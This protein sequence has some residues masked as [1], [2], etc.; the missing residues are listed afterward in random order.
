ML[1]SQIVGRNRAHMRKIKGDG[2]V[3]MLKFRILVSQRFFWW[4]KSRLQHEENICAFLSCF[5]D[6]KRFIKG[7]CTHSQTF[8]RKTNRIPKPIENLPFSLNFR[9][10]AKSREIPRKPANKKTAE[11][12][13]SAKARES[14]RKP[15]NWFLTL[16]WHFEFQDG[17]W[18]RSYQFSWGRRWTHS[19]SND[20]VQ[21]LL[22]KHRLNRLWLHLEEIA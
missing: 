12:G 4:S 22:E 11:I 16:L 7:F 13:R 18:D 3:F 8:E 19:K 14:P 6:E 15:A 2:A 10:S 20:F 5:R 9:L 17:N 21:M 1:N